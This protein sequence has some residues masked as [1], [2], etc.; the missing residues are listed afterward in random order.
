MMTKEKKLIT[1]KELAERAK[2]RPA[3]WAYLRKKFKG[4]LVPTVR[5]GRTDYWKASDV[6]RVQTLLDI[7]VWSGGRNDVR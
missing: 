5:I 1:S 3:T 6:T 7:L 2:V 4:L